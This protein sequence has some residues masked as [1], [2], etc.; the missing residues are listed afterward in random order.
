[1]KEY[2]QTH[3]QKLTQRNKKYYQTHKQKFTQYYKE[4]CQIHK[5]EVIQYN[6]EYRQTH[7]EYFIQYR[8]EY[9]QNN[10]KYFK[11]YQKQRRKVDPRYKLSSN[12]SVAIRLSL[13]G[14]KGGRHWETLIYST[15]EQIENHLKKTIPTSYTYQDYL[16]GKL[17]IDHI[18]P[19][20]K[21]NVSKPEH[22]DFQRCWALSN[23]RLIPAKENRIKSAKIT[24]PF[25]P[26]LAIGGGLKNVKIN[27]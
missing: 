18:E 4:Y 23:L 25:Q 13:K 10:R 17:E 2:R 6:K 26:S 12:M 21:F 5:Q 1:M 24:K 27:S 8:K 20:S 7:K 14:N 11:E 15:K 9:W 19:I 16:S 3:K 22:I